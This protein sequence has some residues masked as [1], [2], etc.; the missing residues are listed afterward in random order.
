MSAAR[1]WLRSFLPAALP[2]RRR[3]L[4]AG[5][6]GTGLALLT[7][8][9]L[10]QAL[11]GSSAWLI[12][13][14]GASAALMFGLPAT[15]LAQPWPVLGGNLVSALVGVACLHWLGGLGT[16][17]AAA[18]AGAAAVAVMLLLRCLHPPGG[19]IALTA[20]IG[21]PSIQQLGYGFA[22]WPVGGGT[23]ILLTLA[24]LYNNA[25]G[26]RYPHHG[27][28]PHTAHATTDPPPSRRLGYSKE[29]LD[30]ALASFDELLDIDRDDLE[31]IL[32]RAHL[33]AQ[34][35]HWGNV[36]CRDIMSR[37]VV[38]VESHAGLDIAWQRLAEHHIKAVPV[39]D[40]QGLLAGIVSMH[41]F[42][43]SQSAPVPRRVPSM[44]TASRVADI[45]TRGVRTARPGQSIAELIGAFS[46]GGLHHM[47]VVEAD[48]HVVGMITQSDLIAALYAR[49]A[50]AA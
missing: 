46:D 23:L 41:D 7:A 43:M 42:F 2:L 50:Q 5:S 22:F 8:A 12:A 20:V 27:P 9:G 16:V 1:T 29:D 32:T 48:G 4:I 13:P 28:A 10:S 33:H 37:D 35:R 26:R 24:L 11:T 6:I 38:T 25:M 19:A 34:S 17:W 3:D 21:G 40:E 14:L 49:E 18:A 39:V 15:P 36:L 44:S 31:E 30:A 47:P 45:M